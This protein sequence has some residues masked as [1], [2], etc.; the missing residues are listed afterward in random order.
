M[1]RL[2]NKRWTVLQRRHRRIVVTSWCQ[3]HLRLLQQWRDGF[4]SFPDAHELLDQSAADIN[5]LYID[6][7][8]RDHILRGLRVSGS[9]I[10]TFHALGDTVGAFWSSP[11]APSP[12]EATVVAGR[13]RPGWKHCQRTVWV[14][15]PRRWNN[16]ALL[17]YE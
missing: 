7:M 2:K 13:S 11:V 10:D 9:P 4:Q 16:V 6:S 3:L 17:S 15:E 5:P 1:R 14:T 12:T 8:T